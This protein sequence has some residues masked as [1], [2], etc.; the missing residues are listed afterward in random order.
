MFNAPPTTQ[1][2]GVQG[3]MFDSDNTGT[4][5]IPELSE[6]LSCMGIFV[7]DLELDRHFQTLD[8]DGSG[9]LTFDEFVGIAQYTFDRFATSLFVCRHFGLLFLSNGP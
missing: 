9:A 3:K 1:W 8:A 4:I 5:S 7:S 6:A 2:W